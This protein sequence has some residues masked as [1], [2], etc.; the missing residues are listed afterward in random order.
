MVM[1]IHIIKKNMIMNMMKI[2]FYNPPTIHILK[3]MRIKI[4]VNQLSR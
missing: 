3:Q 2:N 4:C 1:D